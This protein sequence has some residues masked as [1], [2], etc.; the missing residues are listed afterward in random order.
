MIKALSI[1][2]QN[3]SQNNLKLVEIKKEAPDTVSTG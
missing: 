2:V 1:P 3:A